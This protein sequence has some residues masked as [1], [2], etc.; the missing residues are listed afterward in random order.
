MSTSMQ[1]KTAEAAHVSKD[2]SRLLLLSSH[3]P[4]TGQNPSGVQNLQMLADCAWLVGG[5]TDD[6]IQ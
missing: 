4:A 3:R 1:L 6:A 2:L 5:S